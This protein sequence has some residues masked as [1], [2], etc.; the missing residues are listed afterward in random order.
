MQILL[1]LSVSF[2]T[3]NYFTKINVLQTCHQKVE[4]KK[5][6]LREFWL[7]QAKKNFFFQ[8][9]RKAIM[10]LSSYNE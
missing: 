2:S 5:C 1:N 7:R 10:S 3:D 6:K 8:H 9:H 4:N